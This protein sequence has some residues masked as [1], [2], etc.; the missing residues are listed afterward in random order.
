MPVLELIGLFIAV[1][2]LLLAYRAWRSSQRTIKE[3]ID[4]QRT[5]ARLAE[6]Q[7]EQLENIHSH[8]QSVQSESG[9]AILRIYIESYGRNSHKYILRNVGNA[10]ARNVSFELQPHGSGKNPLIEADYNEKFPAPVVSPGSEIGV[11]AAFSF[12]SARAFDVFLKWE[13]ENGDL[14]EETTF[15]T[16]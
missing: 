16:L 9:S 3:Q 8:N 12:G 10:P 15:V 6:Q 7:L 4:L 11:L 14:V 1:G 5:T 2:S 13:N